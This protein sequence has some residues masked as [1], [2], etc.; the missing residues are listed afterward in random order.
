MS[1]KVTSGMGV[2]KEAVLS[3]RKQGHTAPRQRAA[4]GEAGSRT[5]VPGTEGSIHRSGEKSPTEG[6]GAGGVP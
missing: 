6:V 5:Q 4:L 3:L 2:T 1:D